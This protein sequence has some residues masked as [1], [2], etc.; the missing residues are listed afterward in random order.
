M[1]ISVILLIS[2]AFMRFS[3]MHITPGRTD[4]VYNILYLQRYTR[5]IS[6][7]QS[8]IFSSTSDKVLYKM[9]NAS[10]CSEPNYLD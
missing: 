8:S 6:Y 10:N 4:H 2:T 1:F 3:Q 7:N 9:K 5:K